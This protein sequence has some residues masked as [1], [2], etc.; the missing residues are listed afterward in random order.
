[1]KWGDRDNTLV[2]AQGW[3]FGRVDTVFTAYRINR[4]EGSAKVPLLPDGRVDL[5]P[6]GSAT[7]AGAPID[8]G[9]TVTFTR[10]TEVVQKMISFEETVLS[11]FPVQV[12]WSLHSVL[13]FD[14]GDFP[15]TATFPLVLQVPDPADNLY[16]WF[17]RDFSLT[18]DGDVVA[19]VG[20]FLTN[21]QPLFVNE[22][23]ARQS[24]GELVKGVS[25]LT[26]DRDFP[27]PR[28]LFFAV[29]LT[30]RSVVAKS[31]EDQVDITFRKREEPLSRYT[32]V[33]G[34]F[35][36]N[37]W[38]RGAGTGLPGTGPSLGE[39]QLFR[40]VTESVR[41][42]LYRPELASAGFA[43][44]TFDESS[45]SVDFGLD[46]SATYRETSLGRSKCGPTDIFFANIVASN[47]GEGRYTIVGRKFCAAGQSAVPIQWNP[48]AGTVTRLAGF[49]ASPENLEDVTLASASRSAALIVINEEVAPFKGQQSTHLVTPQQELIFP[50][51][52]SGQ[53]RLLGPNVLLSTT[54]ARLHHLNAALDPLPGPP[55]LAPGGPA[56]G[57]YHFVGQ[58]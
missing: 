40:G 21:S 46:A 49:S 15:F 13:T 48:A 29:N 58:R 36:A 32:F 8:L 42:G 16:N 41:S 12:R 45:F 4:P 5:V 31:S 33:T 47:G 6:L 22:C 53:F 20:L 51:D 10:S 30:S 50:G 24:T 38:V 7:L 1:V 2:A 37:Q 43:E 9:T 35:G 3:Q 44:A 25:C 55:V 56:A 28:G 26:I 19:T 34:P 57:E 17:I 39:V 11:L 54:D 18:R 27:S 14:L 23:W 52:I